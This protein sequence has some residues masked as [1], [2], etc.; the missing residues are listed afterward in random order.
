MIGEVAQGGASGDPQPAIQGAPMTLTAGR[1][2]RLEDRYELRDG[3]IYLS[4]LQALVRIALDQNRL[5]R[6]NGRNTATFISGYE[7][8]P[9]AGF[10]LEL[11]RQA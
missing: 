2:V 7:G 8:S 10:D 11:S 3:E 1:P 6:R 9:L 5:D 4:G